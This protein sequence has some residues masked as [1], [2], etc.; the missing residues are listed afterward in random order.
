MK[1]NDTVIFDVDAQLDEFFGKEGSPERRTAEERANDFFTEPKGST[2][3]HTDA[4][5]GPN[6]QLTPAV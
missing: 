1:A 3:Y 6:V 5:L 4:A 2:F